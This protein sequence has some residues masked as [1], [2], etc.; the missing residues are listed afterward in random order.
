MDED[1]R[2]MELVLVE[3]L[4][5]RD[6]KPI[7]MFTTRSACWTQNDAGMFEVHRE[8]PGSNRVDLYCIPAT[9]VAGI[10]MLDVDL[11]K[12]AELMREHARAKMEQA[13]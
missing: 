2:H 6:G 10:R 7:H 11:A 1:V 13:S 5:D 3:P 8:V 12:Q 4:P 9:N